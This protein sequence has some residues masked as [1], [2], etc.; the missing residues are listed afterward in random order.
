MEGGLRFAINSP[1]LQHG[2]EESILSTGKKDVLTMEEQ[3]CDGFGATYGWWP[4]KTP[5][6]VPRKGGHMRESLVVHVLPMCREAASKVTGSRSSEQTTKGTEKSEHDYTYMIICF[7][8]SC[9]LLVVSSRPWCTHILK[10][11]FGP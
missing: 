4:L 7:N 9:K 6:R 8:K 11:S 1:G 2:Q 3:R 10:Q 5:Q